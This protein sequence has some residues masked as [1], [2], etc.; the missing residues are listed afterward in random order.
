MCLFDSDMLSVNSLHSTIGCGNISVNGS[1]KT[2]R[3]GRRKP[4]ALCLS[5]Q[6]RCKFNCVEVVCAELKKSVSYFNHRNA[7]ILTHVLYLNKNKAS[8]N[9]KR[10]LCLTQ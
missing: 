9:K 4:K 3:E 8:G 7:R 2:E 1:W 5:A 6:T 10:G